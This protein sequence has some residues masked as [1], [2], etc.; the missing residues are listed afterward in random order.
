MLASLTYEANSCERKEGTALFPPHTQSSST[1][2]IHTQGPD[3]SWQMCQLLPSTTSNRL[4]FRESITYKFKFDLCIK[5]QN[6]LGVQIAQELEN[7]GFNASLLLIYQVVFS[8]PI[9]N[10]LSSIPTYTK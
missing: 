4:H 6:G 1:S 5:G 9:N 3:A 8:K 7:Q 2:V 10:L